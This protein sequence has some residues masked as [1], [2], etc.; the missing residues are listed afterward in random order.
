MKE[1]LK[2]AS[3]SNPKVT[4]RQRLMA[5]DALR[6]FD[7]FWIIG[8][9]EIVRGLKR[10]SNSGWAGFLSTQLTHK[11]WEGFLFY[12]LIFPLF[13]FLVGVS[14]VFSLDRILAQE[15]KMA[16]YKRIVRRACLLYLLGIFYYHGME[17]MWPGIRLV[18]VLQRLA[19]CYLF[20]SLLY[21]NLRWRGM[22]ATCVFLLIGYWAL[23]SLV[24]VPE[25][26]AGVMEPGKNL[27]NWIDY[28][29]LPGR[30][31]DGTWD[32]EGLLSTLPA[33]ATCLL[34][35]FSGLLLKSRNLGNSGKA[36]CL[37]T[38]GVICVGVGYAWGF[39]FPVIKK[40]W[41]SSYVLVAGGYSG[42][43]LGAF[44]LIIDVLNL[45]TW[46]QPFVC[47]GLNPLALYLIDNMVDFDE[48]AQRFVGGNIKAA[49]GTYGDLC[50]SLV[51][52]GLII[53]LA[54]YL[55]RKKIFLRV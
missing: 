6:G 30:K 44:V 35:V 15:G 2:P 25:Y 50:V 11:K 23:M 28:H 47:I 32:P 55:Q 31:H 13:V 18:G 20:A 54:F 8:A 24:P 52:L 48:L 40:I 34:G 7:M 29:F 27:A 53:L 9:G 38:A 42:I 26:G 21:C 5:V 49:L 43:L 37:I 17:N 51:S 39:S 16:A 45:R 10:I 22:V 14:L 46:A 3:E 19:L 41:T 1:D 4:A 36:I 12:D 33:V